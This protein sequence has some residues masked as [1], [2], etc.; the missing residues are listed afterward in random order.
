MTDF[1]PLLLAAMLEQLEAPDV[2][3]GDWRGGETEPDGSMQMPWFEYSPLAD[4]Y[5]RA[6]GGGGF[7]LTDFDWMRW[8]ETPA[9]QELREDP[10]R[11]ES[12]SLLELAQLLTAIHRGDR[13]M[14]GNIA[15]AF[16][17]GLIV[18]I[19]RRIRGIG[20]RR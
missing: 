15:G 17:S 16:E 11:V 18:R 12:A 5:M 8:L 20:V 2:S 10:G 19:V 9:T 7:I 4:R 14:E 1:R 13:F 3:F 6:V